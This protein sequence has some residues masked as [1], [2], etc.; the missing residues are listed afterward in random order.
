MASNSRQSTMSL[1][2]VPAIITLAITMLRAV[3]ELNNWSPKLFSK[4]AGG[5]GALIGISWLPFVFGIYFAVK[6]CNAGDGPKSGLKAILMVVIGIAL[7]VVTSVVVGQPKTPTQLIPGALAFLV[8]GLIQL[9]GWPQ[10]AKTLLVYGLAARI[11]SVIVYYLAF[12]HHWGTHYDAIP[13]EFASFFAGYSDV[14]LFINMGLIPQIFLW[15][16]ITMLTGS[17]TGD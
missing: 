17:L 8:A 16:P 6:L 4:E 10:L 3:G 2:L 11:P 14:R 7:I 12:T 5:G 15:I 13:P 1:I 9:I